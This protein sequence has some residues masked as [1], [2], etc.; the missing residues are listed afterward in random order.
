MGRILLRGGPKVRI[1][2]RDGEIDSNIGRGHYWEGP[3]TSERVAVSVLGSDILCCTTPFVYDFFKGG[4]WK[5]I[6]FYKKIGIF[7]K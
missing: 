7:S 1:W 3:A 4:G 2:E 5:E 6:I